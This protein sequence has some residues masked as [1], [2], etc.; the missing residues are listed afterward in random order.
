[1]TS[2]E[3]HHRLPLRQTVRSNTGIQVA[4]LR[5]RLLFDIETNGLLPAVSKVHCIWAVD[6]DSG[7][8]YDFGPDAIDV[9]L[10][11]LSGATELVGH[12]ILGYDLPVLA[13][14]YKDFTIN[15]DCVYTDTLVWA[16]LVNQTIKEDDFTRYNKEKTKREQLG[17][18]HESLLQGINIGR[19]GLAAYGNRYGVAKGDYSSDMKAKGIDPWAEWSQEMHDYCKQDL[20]VNLRLHTELTAVDCSREALELEQ[21]FSV[22]LNDMK[23][24]GFPFDKPAAVKL[25]ATLSD[26]IATVSNQLTTSFPDFYMRTADAVTAARTM[27]FKDPMRGDR[28]KGAQHTP[29]EL[30]QFNP[31]SAIHIVNRLKRFYGYEPT[32]FTAAGRPQ[33]DK[34][35]L[36]ELPY[37]E[38][39]S[40]SDY[41]MLQK[42]LG[43]LSDGPSAWLKKAVDNGSLHSIHGSVNGLGTRTRRCTHSAPNMGQVPSLVNANGKVP[44]GSE[45][46]SLF[47]APQGY[48][49]VGVDASG[50]ELRCLAHYLAYFD[51]GAY[52]DVVTDGDVH[53]TNAVAMGLTKSKDDRALAK[54]LV[55]AILYGAG[56]MLLGKIVGKGPRIGNQIKKKWITNVPGLSTLLAS[57]TATAAN[58]SGWIKTV[59]GSYLF[60]AGEH[61]NMNTLLQ[62]TG[63]IICKLAPLIC[64]ADCEAAGLVFGKDFRYVAH[65]HDEWQALVLDEH[66]D[67][68]A[69]LAIRSVRKAGEHLKLKVRLDAEENRGINWAETH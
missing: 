63:S 12:N 35:V 25:V 41:F 46:R 30:Q 3:G 69:E 1:M 68:Y 26:A 44:Y 32:V 43:Q 36:D 33:M 9:G 15:S 24:H 66:V 17:K 20:V 42:R 50:L 56:G 27:N 16:K 13:H 49:L 61:T 64:K 62:S 5:S 22:L 28:T 58:R 48:T 57:L 18:N 19:H 10:E 38:A 40:I 67:T 34:D 65:I 31:G 53:T 55:Y 51:G 4:S 39:N 29:V 11:L 60:D 21:D 2:L 37:K 45:C 47:Y 52:A 54:R 6:I 8:Y 23:A 7:K 14:I 59:D